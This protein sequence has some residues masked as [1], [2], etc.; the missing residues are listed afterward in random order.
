VTVG[1]SI[2]AYYLTITFLS[3]QINVKLIDADFAKKIG[4]IVSCSWLTVYLLHKFHTCCFPPYQEKVLR[5][6]IRHR[7]DLDK[8]TYNPNMTARTFGDLVDNT[9]APRSAE[10]MQSNGLPSE[11]EPLL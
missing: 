6:E 8:R 4:I 9:Q 1:I 5:G 11:N 10:V 7:D 3:E 2:L